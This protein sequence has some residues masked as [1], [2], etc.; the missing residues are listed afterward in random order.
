[1]GVL[2][3]KAVCIDLGTMIIKLRT[4]SVGNVEYKG[5]FRRSRSDMIRIDS[6]EGVE[7]EGCFGRSRS[8]DKLRTASV[9]GV[10]NK[11]CFRRS[12]SPHTFIPLSS[13][14]PRPQ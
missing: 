3:I 12:P 6:V 7:H 11:G 5:C 9:G 8:D 10:E 13:P 4:G 14:F 2:N 1:M